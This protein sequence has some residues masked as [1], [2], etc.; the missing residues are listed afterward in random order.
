MFLVKSWF[1]KELTEWAKSI[2]ISVILV[3]IIRQFI[4][5]PYLVVGESMQ[6]NF[7]NNDRVIVNRLMY[8]V[9]GPERSDV[10]VAHA[11]KIEKDIIKR[12][13]AVSGDTVQVKGD[14][15]CINK[16]CSIEPYLET[17]IQERQLAHKQYNQLD[18][19]PAVVPNDHVFAL[20]DNRSNSMDSRFDEIGMIPVNEVVG[21]VDIRFWPLHD[22]SII[23]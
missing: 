19:G 9:H 6:P 7:Q 21:R 18:Y 3:I 8:Y 23:H 14:E 1:Q 20:G 12:V 11:P 22:F 16:Y 2:V 13:V 5:I 15:L 4:M 10:I 17:I